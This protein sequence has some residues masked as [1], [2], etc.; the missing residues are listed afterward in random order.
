MKIVKNQFTKYEEDGSLG[1]D[2]YAALADLVKEY[3]YPVCFNFPVGHVTHN[4]PLING[5]RV[6]FTVGEKEVEL[7][8]VF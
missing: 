3:N 8:F 4:L 1:K 2:L 7:K 6:E 5:A